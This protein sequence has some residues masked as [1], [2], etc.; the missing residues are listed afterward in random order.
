ML[1]YRML[2][3]GRKADSLTHRHLA[4]R[5]ARG[6]CAGNGAVSIKMTFV[7][8]TALTVGKTRYNSIHVR[9]L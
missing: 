8:C 3:C 2:H 7:K 1:P 4:I 5:V 6:A 9:R